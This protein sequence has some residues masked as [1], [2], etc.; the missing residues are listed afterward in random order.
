VARRNQFRHPVEAAIDRM[1]PRDQEIANRL[2]EAGFSD[3]ALYAALP[4]PGVDKL[5]RAQPRKKKD[6]K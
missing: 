3:E 1:S 6:A 5:L 2:S 4:N